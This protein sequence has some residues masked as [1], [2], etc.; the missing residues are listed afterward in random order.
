MATAVIVMLSMPQGETASTSAVEKARVKGGQES[1][2][3]ASGRRAGHY[4]QCQPGKKQRGQK[5][6]G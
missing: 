4:P 3:P 1:Q 2:R 5:E 6:A